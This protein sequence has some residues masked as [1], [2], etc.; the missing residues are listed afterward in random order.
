MNIIIPMAGA[1]QRF[2]DAGYRVHKPALPTIDR[3]TGKEYPMVVCATKDLPGVDSNGGNLTYIDRTFH[4]ADLVEQEILK[5][6]PQAQFI[7]TENLTEGQACT[8]LLAKEKINQEEPLL[9]AGCDNGM[10]F[11]EDK[12]RDLTKICDVIVFTYRHHDAVL[13]NPN[14][15]GWVE[16]DQNGKITGLSI[17]KA[18]SDT[19]MEDHA[20]VATFWFR[21]GS[22]FV[23]AA[24]KMIKEND[25]INNEFYVDEVIKHALELGLDARVFEINR[26]LGWGTPKDYETYM[27]TIQY[28]KEFITSADFLPAQFLEASH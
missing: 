20:I 9:I 7:S 23:K 1:G 14:A 28:W 3:R 27:A 24:E 19:P 22:D 17:K 6:Y 11:E 8:C 15:Y 21:H 25:R 12:F 18:L 16:A 4:K 13:A 26:Y 2:A 5:S 10:D